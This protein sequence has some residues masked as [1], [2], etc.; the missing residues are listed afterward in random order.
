[1]SH[2]RRCA[3]WLCAVFLA[4]MGPV[5]AGCVRGNTTAPDGRALE[6]P[7][8]AGAMPD[9]SFWLPPVPA[10]PHRLDGSER[11]F[12]VAARTPAVRQYPC[13]S[14]HRPE[15]PEPRPSRP[16]HPERAHWRIVD[17][18]GSSDGFTC[19]SCHDPREPHRLRD[20]HGRE[21]A[22]DHSYLLCGACHFQQLRDWEGGAHGK[23]LA[24]WSGP[25]VVEPCAGC[26]DPHRPGVE[27]RTP[28]THSPL[29]VRGGAR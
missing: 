14:C 23:R 20:V 8:E 12:S 18:H 5:Q 1:M 19:A 16:D 13:S 17:A 11:V 25:R 4:A 10:V 2:R 24:I 26:H 3:S 21:V 6:A 15:G 9:G 22:L 28:A 27:V 7:A 29:P